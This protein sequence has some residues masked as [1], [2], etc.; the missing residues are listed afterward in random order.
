MQHR[1]ADLNHGE[2]HEQPAREQR[3]LVAQPQS[4]VQ[5]KLAQPEEVEERP[6][7]A[8]RATA[9]RQRSDGRRLR[10]ERIFMRPCRAA[11]R[12]RRR[13]QMTRA[14]RAQAGLR[15]MVDPQVV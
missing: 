1:L 6:Q 13:A 5:L 2:H 14:R 10:H 7:R 8:R 11:V 9:Q 12:P 15:F 3:E 4:R